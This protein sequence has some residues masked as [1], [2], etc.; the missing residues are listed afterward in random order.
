MSPF[1]K[2]ENL[3]GKLLE[4]ESNFPEG[5]KSFQNDGKADD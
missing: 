4:V 2:E 3:L 1:Q 5:P